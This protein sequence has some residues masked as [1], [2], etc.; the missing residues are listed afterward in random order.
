MALTD[1]QQKKIAKYGQKGLTAA[2]TGLGAGAAAALGGAALAGVGKRATSDDPRFSV[3]EADKTR[4]GMLRTQLKEAQSPI[5]EAMVGQQAEQ[6]Y[7]AAM[8]PG[9]QAQTEALRSSL[10]GGLGQGQQLQAFGE[11]A[12]KGMEQKAKATS[13]AYKQAGEQKIAQQK[14]AQDAI[15]RETAELRKQRT[16]RI[17]QGMKIG[18]VV[19]DKLSE[20]GFLDDALGIVGGAIGGTVGGPGGAALGKTL[21]SA[22]GDVIQ[23]TKKDDEETETPEAETEETPET[24][25][26]PEAEEQ[27]EEPPAEAPEEAQAQEDTEG[28]M[29]ERERRLRDS[30]AEGIET[31]EAQ[32]AEAAQERGLTSEER[33]QKRMEA[34]QA[35]RAEGV[36][37]G[38][39]EDDEAPAQGTTTGS[40]EGVRRIDEAA[41]SPQE[42]KPEM[43]EPEEVRSQQNPVSVPENEVASALANIE[44][45]PEYGTGNVADITAINDAAQT[46]LGSTE[47]GMVNA[48]YAALGFKPPSDAI[49]DAAAMQ[50]AM[51]AVRTAGSGLDILNKSVLREQPGEE[52]GGQSNLQEALKDPKTLALIAQLATKVL[53]NGR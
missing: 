44:N 39:F 49:P 4:A 43:L 15:T 24:P 8:G 30:L 23:G 21:G 32:E 19:I 50:K 48:V 10:A 5:D 6:A 31:A 45:L 42:R 22:A 29:S 46:L 38:G 53:S 26:T 18:G 13:E 33:A 16:G 17:S 51:E 1:E 27:T 41:A 35:D 34:R 40:I 3:K 12:E 2:A 9:Q 28:G 47:P 52:E 11:I 36:G 7:Q 20:S 37:E 14:L 25:E